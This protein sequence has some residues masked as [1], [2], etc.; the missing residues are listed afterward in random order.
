MVG[1]MKANSSISCLLVFVKLPPPAEIGDFRTLFVPLQNIF[2]PVGRAEYPE[3]PAGFIGL[4]LYLEIPSLLEII[5]T[6]QMAA[7]A[8]ANGAK[9]RS[10]VLSGKEFPEGFY[11][12]TTIDAPCLAI[13]VVLQFD[14]LP[15][16]IHGVRINEYSPP[17]CQL[18]NLFRYHDPE[19]ISGNVL[20]L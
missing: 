15:L 11:V 13:T 18:G 1:T 19:M 12:S 8:E 6:C 20:L 16:R 17:L 7:L 3:K 2:L 14:F 4:D 9:D 5:M 10:F